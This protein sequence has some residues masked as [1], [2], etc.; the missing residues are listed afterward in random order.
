MAL[1]VRA[2]LPQRSVG[3]RDLIRTAAKLR[4]DTEPWRYG[5]LLEA[6]G[7]VG[8]EGGGEPVRAAPV[9]G[10]PARDAVRLVP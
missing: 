4:V 6:P 3:G 10:V 9:G 7:P 5:V 1:A 8:P 2:S